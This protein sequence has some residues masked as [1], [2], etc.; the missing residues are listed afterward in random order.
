[1]VELTFY[2]QIMVTKFV[3]EGKTLLSDGLVTVMNDEVFLAVR[4][5]S[6][7]IKGFISA[8][9]HDADTFV[10]HL[11]HYAVNR[12]FTKSPFLAQVLS[13]RLCVFKRSDDFYCAKEV[14]LQGKVN[15]K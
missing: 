15:K 8:Y 1:M 9:R 4:S 7:S 2:V 6:Q 3:Q 13:C 10:L 5:R 14:T 11:L 12:V